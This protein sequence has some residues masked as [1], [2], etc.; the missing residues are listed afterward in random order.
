MTDAESG[1]VKRTNTY[2]MRDRE[3]IGAESRRARKADPKRGQSASS[4][5]KGHNQVSGW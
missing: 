4:G 1:T 2:V 3:G 5:V